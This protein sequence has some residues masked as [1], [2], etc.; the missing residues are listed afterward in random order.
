[1]AVGLLGLKVGMTQVFVE[2][3]A[4]LAALRDLRRALVLGGLLAFE[5][6]N[7]G[8]REWGGLDA[9]TDPPDR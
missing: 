7:P 1:M 6:R 5:S 2:D 3:D 8:A 4:W 9:G